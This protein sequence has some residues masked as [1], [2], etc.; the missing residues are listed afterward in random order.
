M[1]ILRVTDYIIRLRSDRFYL[2]RCIYTYGGNVERD[3]VT[4]CF[5][6]KSKQVSRIKLRSARKSAS[7]IER[8]N[9]AFVS[10]NCFTDTERSE[11]AG[12]CRLNRYFDEYSMSGAI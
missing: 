3:P 1:R 10:S 2:I 6:Y 4:T 5:I 12:D 7:L 11:R 8:I 9:A